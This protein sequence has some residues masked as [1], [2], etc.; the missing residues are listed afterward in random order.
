[1]DESDPNRLL[2]Q[3]RRYRQLGNTVHDRHTRL[4]LLEV[5][6][7]FEQRAERLLER[8]RA[9]SSEQHGGGTGGASLPPTGKRPDSDTDGSD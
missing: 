6:F 3:A 2:E 9:Q 1:V 8:S 5:A 7:E 4:A